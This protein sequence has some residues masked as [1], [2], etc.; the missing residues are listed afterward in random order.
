MR[1]REE[2]VFDMNQVM[3]SVNG[4]NVLFDILHECGIGSSLDSTSESVALYNHGQNLIS[5][6]YEAD[7]SKASSIVNK[8]HEPMEV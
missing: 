7:A 2:I 5:I 3:Q 4:L 8:L 1:T 6:M